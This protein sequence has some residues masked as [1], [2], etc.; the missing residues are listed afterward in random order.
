MTVSNF[1]KKITLL[2][3]LTGFT[4]CISAQEY[5]KAILRGD[6]PDPSI[7]RDGDDFYMTHSPFTY[8]P[9]F[10]IW[11][12]KDLINW[13]PIT[14]AMPDLV[15][16]AMAPDLLKHNG[17]YYIYFPA[18][19]SNWVI[20]A[21]DIRG[22][23]SKPIDLKVPFIDPGHAIGEDGK[24]YLFVSEGRMAPLSKDGLSA[25]DTLKVVYNGWD[26]PKSWVTE[27]KCLESPKIFKKGDYFY[28][29]TAEGGT[30]G[31]ATSHMVVAARSKSIQ[32]PWENSPYNPIVH[33][34]SA[35]EK[36]WSKGHGTLIDDVKGNWWIVYHA[37]EKGFHTLGRQTLI[38]PIEWTKDGWFRTTKGKPAT[39]AKVK[40]PSSG[41]ML[42]DNFNKETLGLQWTAWQGYDSNATQLKNGSLH[43]KAKGSGPADA[44]LLLTTA[45]DT[46]YETQVE[47]NLTGG[48]TGG[49][50]LFYNEKAFAGI[51]SNGKDV[52]IYENAEKQS[53]KPA[54][55]GKHFYLKIKNN[56]NI[57]DMLASKDGK[58]W[59]TLLSGLDVSGLN[60]NK[61]RGFFA[62][63]P[64]FMSAGKE[65][66]VILDNFKYKSINQVTSK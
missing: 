37:Y 50:I 9:G 31:P 21:N 47:V 28:M 19:G 4:F 60:H 30:A 48:G 12:S 45:T 7:M 42:S 35:D 54:G 39:E 17:K 10:L 38:E 56:R 29:V 61:Y 36:W 55:L 49:L 40:A 3:V 59:I 22:P 51:T 15:G 26:Y 20:W 23:W 32:G 34:Y 62:L 11:H 5:P 24:R 66:T 13:T 53:N 27:C 46:S 52:T 14:R 65:G 63:R 2:L 57:C 44:Q 16:S 41:F 58:N 6:Y 8:S 43:L 18:K 64:G 25:I 1:F 33:T